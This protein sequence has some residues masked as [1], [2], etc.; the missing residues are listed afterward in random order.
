MATARSSWSRLTI[1]LLALTIVSIALPAPATV[2]GQNGKI[3]FVTERDG[4]AEIYLMDSD[5][6]NLVNLTQNTLGNYDPDW[7]P[8]GRLLVL[9]TASEIT[10]IEVDVAAWWSLFHGEHPAWSPD[11]GR[12]AFNRAGA[13]YVAGHFGTPMIR[14][15]EPAAMPLPIGI[16]SVTDSSPAWSPDGSQVAFV[17]SYEGPTAKF[18]ELFTASASC[19]EWALFDTLATDFPVSQCAIRSPVRLPVTAWGL[20]GP[21]WSPDGTRIAVEAIAADNANSS[22]VV[23]NADGSSGATLPMPSGIDHASTP[24]WSPDGRQMAVTMHG[25]AIS[26]D[27]YVMN[28]D[29]SNPINLTNSPG[30]DYQ[31]AWQ[32]LNPY[33]V[34]LVDRTGLWHF[35]ATDGAI[36]T[37]WYGN[38]ISSDIPFMGDWDCDG[39]DTV[40]VYRPS[41]GYVYLRNSNTDGIGDVRFFLGNPGDE[42]L[43]GDFDGDGCDTVSVYRGAE[44]R[45]YVSNHLG[46]D[47]RGLGEADYS[48]VFGNPG[49]KPFV[50]DFNGDGIDTVGLHRES[51]GMVYYRNNH[52]QGVA[53]NTFVFGDPGDLMFAGDWN[54]D[55]IESP[56]VFRSRTSTF[57][58]KFTNT[59]GIADAQFIWGELPFGPSCPSQALPVAG[60]F[61]NS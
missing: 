13:I 42:P 18:T 57:Y 55:G 19:G 44:T 59:Q 22:I 15:T 35:R 34:G 46:S 39:E 30:P 25:P 14:I 1:A 45:V 38:G 11:G 24:E 50:G 9:V 7:S 5:G 29:G 48:Y 26:Q 27:I 58:F 21:D 28:A 61:D 3:V 41:D 37:L 10:T 56:A 23:V 17:R 60:D 32:P 2:S 53:D 4:N 6:S 49:D 36:S 47:D 54:G 8:D 33:P 51:T 31:P 40:G 12:F 52:S 20:D 16:T 43:P